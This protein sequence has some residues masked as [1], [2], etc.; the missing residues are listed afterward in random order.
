M[1]TLL[2]N[3][4]TSSPLS[5]LRRS[6][7]VGIYSCKALVSLVF[8]FERE[9]PS[10]WARRYGLLCWDWVVL[11]LPLIVS[12]AI[13]LL[14][15]VSSTA[16]TARGLFCFSCLLIRFPSPRALKVLLP[17]EDPF[18]GV[19]TLFRTSFTRRFWVAEGVDGGLTR[20]SM[21]PRKDLLAGCSDFF[22]SEITHWIKLG[23][24]GFRY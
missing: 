11:A 2:K 8:S 18:D 9:V 4:R 24:M 5:K 17:I 6:S 20:L 22:F 15:G 13:I 3:Y 16:D 12:R 14:F 1:P 7:V 21:Y 10:F 23:V 19:L